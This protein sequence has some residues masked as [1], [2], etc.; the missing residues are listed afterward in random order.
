VSRRTIFWLVG[1]LAGTILLAVVGAIVFSLL[2]KNGALGLIA[3]FAL[4]SILISGIVTTVRVAGVYWI[5]RRHHPS[6]ETPATV[7]APEIAA[8][9]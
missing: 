2:D 4:A 1:A 7:A 5:D 9:S 6:E 8:P 3:D